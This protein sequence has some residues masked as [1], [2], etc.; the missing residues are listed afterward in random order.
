LSEKIEET[1]DTRQKI[2]YYLFNYWFDTFSFEA[3]VHFDPSDNDTAA[4]TGGSH[5]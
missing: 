5:D 2:A 4:L 3:N 1:F